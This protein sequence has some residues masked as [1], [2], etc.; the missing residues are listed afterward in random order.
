M[1]R[2]LEVTPHLGKHPRLQTLSL[3]HYLPKP[4]VAPGKLVGPRSSMSCGM[5]VKLYPQRPGPGFSHHGMKL[6]CSARE[7]DTKVSHHPHSIQQD[8]TWLHLQSPSLSPLPLV[9][10]WPLT[11]EFISVA[12]SPCAPTLY[13]PLLPF[14]PSTFIL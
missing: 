5:L 7:S 14:I 6:P 2:C 9:P 10:S 12:S 3:R 4:A 1:H 13:L 11:L 8:R